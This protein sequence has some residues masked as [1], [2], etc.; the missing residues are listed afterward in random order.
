MVCYLPISEDT[1]DVVELVFLT[2]F[3]S[4]GKIDAEPY[5]RLESIRTVKGYFVQTSHVGLHERENTS[6]FWVKDPPVNCEAVRH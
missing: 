3:L 1:D 2:D 4:A 5:H 6:L